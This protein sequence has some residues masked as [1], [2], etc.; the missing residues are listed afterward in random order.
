VPLWIL[1]L[2]E[3]LDG[4]EI[5]DVNFG[6]QCYKNHKIYFDQKYKHHM[7]FVYLTKTFLF[8]LKNQEFEV[9]CCFQGIGQLN[10]P[11]QN[12]GI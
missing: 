10:K 4:V 11:R 5:C 2:T 1:I 7:L 9:K 8:P 3:S 12:A 6:R